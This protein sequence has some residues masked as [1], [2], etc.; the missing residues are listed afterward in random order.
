ARLGAEQPGAV[1]P[2]VRTL[3]PLRSR[4]RAGEI[5][6]AAARDA[7]RPSGDVDPNE[8]RIDRA[9]R[10]QLSIAWAADAADGALSVLCAANAPF[11]RCGWTEWN[12]E[13]AVAVCGRNTIDP[14]P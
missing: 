3:L 1:P 12:V 6:R 5:G 4:L 9:G 13:S 14:P 7:N 11:G 2:L 10:G 8:W